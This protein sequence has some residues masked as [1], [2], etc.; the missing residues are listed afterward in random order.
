M[1]N[2]EILSTNWDNVAGPPVVE[3]PTYNFNWYNK[4]EKPSKLVNIVISEWFIIFI[5]KF[6][7]Y[8]SN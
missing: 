5:T 3:M 8:I 6:I 1:I 7:F 2:D 4:P